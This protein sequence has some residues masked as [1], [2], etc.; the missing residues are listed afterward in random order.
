MFRRLGSK[1][2]SA[3]ALGLARSTFM[4]RLT[5]AQH[6]GLISMEEMVKP[7]IRKATA[8]LEREAALAA[9]I[10]HSVK[11]ERP[12]ITVDD[13]LR[14]RRLE[15]ELAERRKREKELLDRLAVAEEYRASV[16][17]LAGRRLDPRGLSVE[18]SSRSRAETVILVL[19]DLHFGEH[20]NAE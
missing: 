18:V 4:N 11:Q 17:D 19:S 15:T 7:D 1:Q 14:E 9:A 12:E 2:L 3:N 5:H 10:Q 6:R 16:M 8:V 13:R 20:I